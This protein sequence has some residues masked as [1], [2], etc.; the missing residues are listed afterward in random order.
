MFVFN[1]SATRKQY[2]LPYFGIIALTVLVAWATGASE[3]VYNAGIHGAF[4][5]GLRL[6]NNGRALTFLMY[7]IVVRI[8][9]FTLRARRLHDTNRSNWWIFIDM[10]PVIGQIWLFILTVLPS[11]PMINRWPVNQTDAE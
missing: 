4:K 6:G 10:V 1:A 5:L 7:Y 11:N 9:N 8:A 2:W 3:F